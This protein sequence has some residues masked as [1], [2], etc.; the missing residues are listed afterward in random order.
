[1]NISRIKYHN[2]PDGSKISVHIFV[3][4]DGIEMRVLLHADGTTASLVTANNSTPLVTVTA[5][6]PHKIRIKIKKALAGVMGIRLPK[7]KRKPRAV[8]KQRT[9]TDV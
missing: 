4:K 1:M 2:R 9:E 5:S 6:S 3:D 7:E 8:D